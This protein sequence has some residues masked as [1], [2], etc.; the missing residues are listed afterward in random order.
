MAELGGAMHPDTL[1]FDESITSGGYLMRYLRFPDGG[2]HYRAIGGGLGPGMPNPIGMKLAR[3][4]P[5][6]LSVIGDGAALYRTSDILALGYL[7][8][9]VLHGA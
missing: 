9:L 3:P 2:R 7:A 5:P 4:D 8:N 1:L 6:I